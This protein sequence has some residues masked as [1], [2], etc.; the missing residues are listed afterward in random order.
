MSL[1]QEFPSLDRLARYAR[2]G[3]DAPSGPQRPDVAK[4]VTAAYCQF[5]EDRLPPVLSPEALGYLQHC[6]A[7]ATRNALVM[8]EEIQV[9][10]HPMLVLL[11]LEC[12]HPEL[13]PAF[14]V[15][16]F[17]QPTTDAAPVPPGC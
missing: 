1:S 5:V 10:H 2:R 12:G 13:L 16:V 7:R 9:D 14:L 4:E 15:A 17:P 11:A 3:A 8:G 6:L